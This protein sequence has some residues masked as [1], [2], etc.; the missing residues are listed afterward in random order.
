MAESVKLPCGREAEFR[1]DPIW[2]RSPHLDL[3]HYCMDCGY[4]ESC[5]SFF[6]WYNALPYSARFEMEME[7]KRLSREARV[8]GDKIEAFRIFTLSETYRNLRS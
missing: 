1:I 5:G 7:L 3:F 4:V 8:R 2:A 6:D